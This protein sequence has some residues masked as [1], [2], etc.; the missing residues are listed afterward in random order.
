[1]AFERAF[2]RK[3]SRY[4]V[5]CAALRRLRSP[6]CIV[7]LR[8]DPDTWRACLA[9][10]AA[11][12]PGSASAASECKAAAAAAAVVEGKRAAAEEE[13]DELVLELE[14]KDAGASDD[15]E[16]GSGSGRKRGDSRPRLSW[17][18]ARARTELRAVRG[19]YPHILAQTRPLFDTFRY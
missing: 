13:G 6:E 9:E 14:A 2:Q 5:V 17:A 18:E 1:M 16:A 19:M 8:S 4:R 7:Q 10:P 12:M 11:T 3:Q 15:D